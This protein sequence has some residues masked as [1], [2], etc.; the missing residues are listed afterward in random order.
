MKFTLRWPMV[1][2]MNELSRLFSQRLSRHGNMLLKYLRLVFTDHFVIALFFF[3]GA[4]GFAYQNGLKSLTAGVWW[5]PILT[6]VILTA[7]SQ[8]G[9]LA[10][11]IEPA[12]AVLLLPAEAPLHTYLRHARNYSLLMASVIQVVIGVILVPFMGQADQ[13]S[14]LSAGLMIVTQILVKA[15]WMNLALRQTVQQTR[16]TVGWARYLNWIVPLVIFASGV[17][18]SAWLAVGLGILAVALTSFGLRQSWVRG[19]LAWHVLVDEE[20]NRMMLLYRF[21]NLFTDVPQVKATVKR[22]RYLDPLW[23]MIVGRSTNPYLYL[24]T[25]GLGR[26]SDTF[27]LVVRLTVIGMVILIFVH[28]Q[29]IS[30]IVMLLAVYL[31]GFQLLPF[32]GQYAGKVFTHLYPVTTVMQLAAFRRVLTVLLTLTA[33]ALVAV[34]A[35]VNWSWVRLGTDIFAL[36]L[37]LIIF[38]GWYS[39]L[40]LKKMAM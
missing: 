34:D 25:R 40:R 8:L 16:L 11:L 14:L 39:R 3:F 31:I 28:S 13:L 5:G 10:T 29:V 4:L 21:F 1:S 19:Q 35:S 20:S 32:Y 2:A 23:R 30:L 38:V 33:V 9:R 6:V 37:E 18:L 36:G 27:G 22:R 7:G 26:D 15:A 17:W 12:D 24:F